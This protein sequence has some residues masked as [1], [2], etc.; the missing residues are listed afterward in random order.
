MSVA[1]TF[2]AVLTIGI[3]LLILILWYVYRVVKDRRTDWNKVEAKRNL[4]KLYAE[5][6]R[7]FGP[8]AYDDPDI[9]AEDM[10]LVARSPDH[11]RSQWILSVLEEDEE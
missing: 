5:Q 2:M 3:F 6:P 10:E 9:D 7:V 8:K 4:R 11:P 1:V